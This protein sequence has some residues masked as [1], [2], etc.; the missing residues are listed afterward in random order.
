MHNPDFESVICRARD[1]VAFQNVAEKM[2]VSKFLLRRKDP[3][4][5]V[6]HDGSIIERAKNDFVL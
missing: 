4:N 5:G 3:V 1:E 2:K 6:Y